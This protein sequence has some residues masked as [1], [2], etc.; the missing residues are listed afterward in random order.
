M[1]LHRYT[2]QNVMLYH[3]DLRP[4]EQGIVLSVG[5]AVGIASNILLVGPA[6]RCLGS[7]RR[8][9]LLMIFTLGSC[10]V[11]YAFTGRENLWLFYTL[12]A[13]KAAAAAMLYTVFTSLFTYA[14][15]LK[16]VGTAVAIAHAVS[17]ASGIVTPVAGNFI[18]D[19]YDFMVLSLVA[20]TILGAAFVHGLFAIGLTPGRTETEVTPLQSAEA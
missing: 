19:R 1:G 5:A 18:Y 12:I 2:F 15:P 10:M 3:F 9:A 6:L 17:T 11:V 14:V 8:V 13:P 20:A 16:L 7:E 4:S